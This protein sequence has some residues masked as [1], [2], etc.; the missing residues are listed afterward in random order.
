MNR[1]LFA[2][3]IFRNFLHGR[4][5]ILSLGALMLAGLF[6]VSQ[7]NY[8]L[9][10]SLA[11]LFSIIIASTIFVLTWNARRMLN[12][13]YLLVI[14]ISFLF[15]A[16]LDLMHTMAFK[17]MTIFP[18]TGY[19][20]L[21]A[22]NLATQLWLATRFM[23]SLSLVAAPSFLKRK[24][25]P[26]YILGVYI[27][28]TAL[29][30]LSIFQW[31][32]FPDAF[33][34]GTGLTPF[35]LGSE[36]AIILLYGIGL[37]RL[38][39]VRAQFDHEI[40]L[41]LAGFAVVNMA[42]DLAF[43]G[44]IQVTDVINLLGHFLKIVA[45]YLIY[46]AIIETGF[47]KPQKLLFRD[48]EQNAR[49]LRESEARERDRAVQLEAI[50]D[51]VPAVVLI[52]HDTQAHSVTGNSAS[53]DLLHLQPN[54]EHRWTDLL[55]QGSH[56]FF[57]IDGNELSA[58]QLPLNIAAATGQ[59]V[60]DFE[61]V[62]IY[63]AENPRNLYGSV[64]PLL[65]QNGQPAG[66]V[67]AFIDITER[68]RAEQA[69]QASE[70]RYRTLFEE[71][72]EGF[73]LQ[74]V[75]FDEDGQAVNYRFIEVNPAF[76]KLMGLPAA[77][78]VGKTIN[79]LTP[80]Q[81]S[82]WI[83]NYARVVK[84]GAPDRFEDYSYLAEKYLEVLVSP[85]GNNVCASMSIDVS[86]RHL[87][88]EALKQSEARLRRLV[89]SNII[90]ITYADTDGHIQLAND[91]YLEIIGYTRDDLAAGR[92]NWKHLTPTEYLALD[93]HGIGEADV[94]GAC[95]PYEKE[96][97]RKDGTRVPVM[98]GYAYFNENVPI[99]ICFVLDMTEQ[100]RA[101]AAVRETAARLERTNHELERANGELQDFAFV[102]SHDLQEPLRKIQAFGER[103]NIRLAGKL[104]PD[105][106]DYLMRMGSAANRMRAMIND[107]LSLS[108]I[109]T[110]GHP[111]EQ[112]DLNE[113]LE[114]VLS[115]LELRI[116]RAQGQVEIADTLPVIEADPLQMHQLLLNLIGNALKFYEP[117]RPPRVRIS[118]DA[119]VGSLHEHAGM[120]VL[121]FEDNG[122]G[123]D[124]QYLERIFQ[125]FQR[126]H[127]M[128][129]YEGSGIGLA[130]CRK[131]V[132]RHSGLITARSTPGQ[133]ATF[134]VSLPVRQ[135]YQE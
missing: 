68:V 54:T 113:T 80:G 39:R 15:T 27:V 58:D 1:E 44:Y 9:F 94:R 122:I 117:G 50:M 2:L 26:R 102:A 116:E 97:I 96:Y 103:L 74:E 108:R 12:N 100:K 127:G 4:L 42:T 107:L 19:S 95:T 76:E 77:Q 8:L 84:S 36:Y 121:S 59:P 32:I 93:E 40:L 30:L 115:D 130:I 126:L 92:V 99:Y 7:H 91:A 124:P 110:R 133:G 75:E 31:K 82:P 78:M 131:I 90:G 132:E 73:A 134:I 49:A 120:V 43:T 66:A 109:T 13:G 29:L 128:D 119:P 23:Q 56:H 5:Q 101:E 112:V 47:L 3:N 37:L 33:L 106:Q 69:F 125:P 16:L 20:E 98:I 57:D 41:L 72:A 61:E 67:A 83:Q 135:S 105:S 123:F 34:D 88:R 89:D 62:F 35:K 25:M 118:C 52:A 104:D 79:E 71:M 10:H 55:S 87:S 22:A 60:L 53:A 129:Q 48:L 70:Q 114:G 45:S 86:E 85:A 65:D 64:T 38:M 63:N 14:G 28:L 17:G 11:E 111:F 6:V 46:K 24:V 81:V 51:A 21:N 18:G